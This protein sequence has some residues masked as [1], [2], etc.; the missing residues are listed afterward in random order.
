[1]GAG[2]QNFLDTTHMLGDSQPHAVPAPEESDI[3]GHPRHQNACAHTHKH[4]YI[5]N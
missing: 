3:S 4:T 1:M 5:H 2:G